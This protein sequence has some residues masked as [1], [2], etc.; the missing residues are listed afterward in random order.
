MALSLFR[1][2]NYHTVWKTAQRA[3]Y[4]GRLKIPGMFVFAYV[5]TYLNGMDGNMVHLFPQQE[6]AYFRLEKHSL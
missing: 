1:T 4:K 2:A 6:I 3:D 5:Y